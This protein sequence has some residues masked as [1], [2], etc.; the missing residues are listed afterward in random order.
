MY[1]GLVYDLVI[2]MVKGM[3]VRENPSKLGIKADHLFV[4][5]A[6]E[7]AQFAKWLTLKLTA[8]GYK[9][10]CDRVKLLGGESYPRDIDEAIKKQTFRV[11]ALLSYDSIDKPNPRK[12]RTLA[13]NI[14]RD[15][16]LD[17]IIPIK[18]DQIKPAE[19]DWMTEMDPEIRTGG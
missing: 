15:R 3:L 8:E 7:D 18:V 9:V 17:F 2:L 12:E 14:S 11:L 19:L 16:E 5:Y 6:V 10:W 4:S 1:L 13:H